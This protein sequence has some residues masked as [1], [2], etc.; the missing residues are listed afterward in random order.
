MKQPTVKN[1]YSVVVIRN[2]INCHVFIVHKKMPQQKRPKG[3]DT[4]NRSKSIK[5][6]KKK[7][8]YTSLSICCKSVIKNTNTTQEEV[9]S[10]KQHSNSFNE[11]ITQFGLKYE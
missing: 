11:E 8:Y 10:Q 5:I 3:I 6:T 9:F 2:S 4:Q 7:S 1:L